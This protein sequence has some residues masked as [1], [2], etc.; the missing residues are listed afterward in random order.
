MYHIG[1]LLR[2]PDA[3]SRIETRNHLKHLLALA[4][5]E[6]FR[7]SGARRDGIDVNTFAHE[8]FRH[9]AHHLLDGAFGG[10]VE[11][12]AGHDGGGG[13]EGGRKEDYV[14]A[15]GHVG[16]SFLQRAIST[17]AHTDKSV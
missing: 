5:V 12:V 13:G 9:D 7:T 8:V 1:N 17:D 11:E 14:R 10:I 16:E 2:R 4:L 6:E 15:R 3:I